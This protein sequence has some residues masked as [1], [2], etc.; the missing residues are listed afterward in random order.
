MLYTLSMPIVKLSSQRQLTIPKWMLELIGAKAHDKLAVKF[1]DGKLIL[2]L[3]KE[4]WVGS[5]AGSLT[6]LIPEDKIDIPVDE[7]IEMAKEIAA[8]EISRRGMK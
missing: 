5:L 7:A 4:D 6:H 3:V 8:Q 2:E 1:E